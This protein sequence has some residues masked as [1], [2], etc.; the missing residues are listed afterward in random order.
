VHAGVED[1]EK[2]PTIRKSLLESCQEKSQSFKRANN[3]RAACQSFESDGVEQC[4][5]VPSPA[6]ELILQLKA[7]TLSVSELWLC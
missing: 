5:G 6:H 4:L 3:Q 1:Q 7:I 2:I